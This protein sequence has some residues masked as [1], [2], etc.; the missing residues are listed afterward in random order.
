VSGVRSKFTLSS[1][2][3]G[4]I[5]A[6][7]LLLLSVFIGFWIYESSELR[8]LSLK[9]E[10]L[11]HEVVLLDR[12]V[13]WTKDYCRIYQALDFL[14]GNKMSARKR[15][16]LAD[17][18]W[19]I[20]RNYNYDPLLILAIVMQES[21]GNPNA[22]GRNRQGEASGAYGLMQ[23]KLGTAQSLGRKFGMKINTEEDL[24]YPEV[25]IAI[26]SAYLMRLLGRYGDLKKAI[27]A[28]NLGTGAVDSK[29][30]QKEPIPT[31]YYEG[32]LAKYRKLSQE[33]EK[34]MGGSSGV[35]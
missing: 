12:Y 25:S 18:I 2:S 20:S 22:R 4:A 26:G 13:R 35:F 32:V 10:K 3:S 16:V 7:A 17:N 29:L 34:R 28:Y 11:Q 19:M 24:L 23:L 21:R 5:L 14:A 8:T 1:L 15:S 6:L 9:E 27:I 31:F 30:K 33:I